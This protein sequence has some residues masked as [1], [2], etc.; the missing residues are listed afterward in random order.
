VA[1]PFPA[2][3]EPAGRPGE[4]LRRWLATAGEWINPVLLKELKQSVRARFISWMLLIYLGLNLLVLGMVLLN[5]E[6]TPTR[7][8]SLG[9]ETFFGLLVFLEIMASVVVPC[10]VAARMIAERSSDDLDLVLTTSIT[11]AALVRGKLLSGLVLV[12]LLHSIALPFMAFT[13]LL[14]GID[15]PS[16]LVTTS[17]SALATVPMLQ[18]AILIAS[19]PVRNVIRIVLVILAALSLLY[20]APIAVLMLA[21]G[22]VSRGTGFIMPS[23]GLWATTAAIVLVDACLVAVLASWSIA[24]LSPRPANRAMPPR[25]AFTG[26]WLVTGGIATVAAAMGE[27]QVIT[28]WLFISLELLGLLMLAAVSERDA[29]GPHV[30]RQIPRSRVLRVLAFPFFTGA[31]NGLAWCCLMSALTLAVP[32]LGQGTA[33]W[34]ISKLEDVLMLGTA[35]VLQYLCYALAAYVLHRRQAD[36]ATATRPAWQL[37]LKLIAAGVVL[38]AALQI[39]GAGSLPGMV[40]IKPWNALSPLGLGDPAARA[41]V[42]YGCPLVLILLA[43]L[44]RPRLVRQIRSF[45]PRLTQRVR[46][47]GHPE[48]GFDERARA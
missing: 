46:S 6:P 38:A 4:L 47:P 36:R 21:G 48:S 45:R 7:P 20:L 15:L 28:A 16:I 9:S 39:L 40:G 24:A 34:S 35:I 30:A 13:Y 10:F 8:Q 23:A 37:G 32:V 27:P 22:L 5:L 44:A 43:A 26:A 11:P 42:V 2:D 3:P 18:L 12:V 14:R 17:I 41:V 33:Q 1:R 31:A 25:L 19:L 29:P